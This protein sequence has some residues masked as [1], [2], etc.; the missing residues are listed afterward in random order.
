MMDWQLVRGVSR[1]FYLTLRWMRREVRETLALGYLLARASDS[2]ADTSQT[3]VERR[4]EALTE[5]KRGDLGVRLAEE[6]AQAQES[7]REAE[8][9]RRLP[10]WIEA[11]DRSP[12]RALLEWVWSQIIDGQIFDLIRFDANPAPLTETELDEYTYSVAGCVGEFWTRLCF[13]R[14][15]RFSSTPLN[16]MV[17]LGV[18][19]GKGLQLVNILRDR[20]AD[21]EIGRV[22]IPDDR[23]EVEKVRASAGLRN[24]IDWAKQ[25]QSRRVRFACLIPARIG[26]A[27]LPKIEANTPRA[28]ISRAELRRAVA[29]SLT[30]FWGAYPDR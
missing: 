24:G 25:V 10:Q 3:T 8:I 27:T 30:S 26:L 22:Y 6:L 4:L 18:A 1:S 23:F 17:D 14:I 2:I 13:T 20:S 12:D 9:V 19:Y 21:A 11:M 29:D 7:E 15:P 16:E 5:M 28:K